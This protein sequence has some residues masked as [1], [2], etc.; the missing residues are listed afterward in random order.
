MMRKSV[1]D[2][3]LRLILQEDYFEDLRMI[4]FVTHISGESCAYS[5]E[6]DHR[7]VLQIKIPLH[8]QSCYE[9]APPRLNSEPSY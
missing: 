7:P 3:A 6:V 2:K 9:V 4:S 5:I 8:C 1:L